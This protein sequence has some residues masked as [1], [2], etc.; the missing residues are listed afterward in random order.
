M[1]YPNVDTSFLEKYP[2]LQNERDRKAYDAIYKKS[3]HEDYIPIFNKIEKKANEWRRLY[4][5]LR[6]VSN[7]DIAG[8][9]K[10]KMEN[11]GRESYADKDVPYYK[12]L[13]E[14]LAHLKRMGQEWHDKNCKDC[15]ET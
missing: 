3:Y 14:K 11:I 12:Y 7:D 1:V 13:H 15:N 10:A 4:A 9:I 2:P 5:S 8:N 6:D